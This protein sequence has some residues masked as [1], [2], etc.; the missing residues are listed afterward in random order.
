MT[1]TIGLPP[2]SAIYTGNIQRKKPDIR[3]ISYD[4][5]NINIT[6]NVQIDELGTLLEAYQDRTSWIHIKPISDQESIAKIGTNL[7]LHLLI[8]ED[9][10][11]IPHRPKAEEFDKYTFIIINSIQ[12]INNSL[13]FL[14]ISFILTQKNLF[15]FADTTDD[16][17][18]NIVN[19]LETP[20][21]RIRKSDSQYL[22]ITLLD[23][24]TDQYFKILEEIGDEIEDLED[25]IL[26]EPTKESIQHVHQLKRTLMELKKSVWPMRELTNTLMRSDMINPKYNIFFKDIYDHIINIMDIIEGYR[27][28]TASFLDIYLSTL[29]NRMNEIM[30]TL[31]IISTIFIPMGFITGY[32]GMN[33]QAMANDV[34]KTDTSYFY[35]N[36]GM[37]AI[38][39][40][41]LLYFKIRKWF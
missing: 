10:L 34:L 18:E 13:N 29:S 16:N 40:V 4:D 39:V 7:G 19:R 22:L 8:I 33:F 24:I 21:S 9:I 2:G 31:S 41:L 27:D 12:Y 20:G 28:T 6:N 15:S 3:V 37:I 14:Q 17:F 11:S 25:E 35:T 23:Y 30:K 32:F 36:V 38:P 5:E 1:D 26:N